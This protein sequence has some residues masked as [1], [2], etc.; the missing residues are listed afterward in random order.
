[1]H[2]E[3]QLRLRQGKSLSRHDLWKGM[4]LGIRILPPHIHKEPV[5]LVRWFWSKSDIEDHFSN[6]EI[7]IPECMRR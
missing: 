3:T 4:V 2:E 7:E 6:Q 5:V 1:M